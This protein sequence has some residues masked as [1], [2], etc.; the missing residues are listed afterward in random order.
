[1]LVYACG[2]SVLCKV[3]EEVPAL[4]SCWSQGFSSCRGKEYSRTFSTSMFSTACTPACAS[5]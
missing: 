1:M 3:Q 2:C 4:R 5:G